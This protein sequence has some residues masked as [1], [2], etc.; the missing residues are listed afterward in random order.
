MNALSVFAQTCD[1]LKYCKKMKTVG[2]CHDERHISLIIINLLQTQAKNASYS[3][4]REVK[5]FYVSF[6][7]F[8]VFEKT[9]PPFFDIQ[10]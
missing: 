2:H 5:V 6:S 4:H 8:N 1:F 3:Q 9:P 10:L 7:I